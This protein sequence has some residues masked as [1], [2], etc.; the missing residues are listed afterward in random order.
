MMIIGNEKCGVDG[1]DDRR[2]L[3]MMEHDCRTRLVEDDK[4]PNSGEA[5]RADIM[6]PQVDDRGLC[7]MST[8]FKC[9]RER[10]PNLMRD[11]TRYCNRGEP[12][13]H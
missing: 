6:S 13:K 5:I 10:V 8:P 9:H 1:T 12:W 4:N 2:V 11:M 7:L 3:E